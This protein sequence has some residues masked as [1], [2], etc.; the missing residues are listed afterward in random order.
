MTVLGLEV[1]DDAIRKHGDLAKPLG[2]WLT[3]AKNAA[4]KNLQE[5]RLTAWRDTDYVEGET[6]FN[7]KGNKYRLAALVNYEAQTMVLLRLQTHAEY[8]KR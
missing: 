7:I 4:W 2:A 6:I 8:S 5:I 3:I 1:L